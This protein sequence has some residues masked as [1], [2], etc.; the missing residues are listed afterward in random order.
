MNVPDFKKRYLDICCYILA[1]NFNEQ[2]LFPII[3]AQAD[4]IRPHIMEDPNYIFN[5]DFYE[6]DMGNGTGGG[7]GAEIPA[8]KWLLNR[9]FDQL[10]ENMAGQSHDCGNASSLYGW[11]DMVINEFAASNVDPGGIPDPTGGYGDWIEIYNNTTAQVRLDNFYLTDDPSN[12]LRWTFPLNTTIEPNGYLIVWADEDENQPGIH[13]NFKLSK[14][15]EFLMLMH[16]D[17]SV[18]DSLTFGPQETNLT[19]SRVPNGSGGFV[20][21]TPTHGYNN[22][23]ISAVNNQYVQQVKIY[24]NPSDGNFLVDFGQ[25]MLMKQNASVSFSNALGQ[26]IPFEMTGNSHQLFISTTSLP[27]GCYFLKIDFGDAT[28]M[29]KRIMIGH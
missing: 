6:Y 25:D 7:G 8:L 27:D 20:I 11:H 1:N 15:G 5:T 26:S 29:I 16:E 12:P 24:P 19:S 21:K 17:G 28:S 22:E 14:S 23:W 18:I 3:D 4:L 10:A 13:T 2:R 9:R